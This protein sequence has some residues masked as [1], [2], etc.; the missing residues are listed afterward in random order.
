MKNNI[1]A[2]GASRLLW[3]QKAAAAKS[4]EKKQAAELARIKSDAQSDDHA[5][6]MAE[7]KHHEK[8]A[9]HKPSAGALW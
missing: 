4:I 5:R 3:G 8:L 6:L 2:G 7:S 1:V 9:S